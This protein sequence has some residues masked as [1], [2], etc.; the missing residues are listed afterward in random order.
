MTTLKD[1]PVGTIAANAATPNEMYPLLPGVNRVDVTYPS[2]T[3][4]TI[5]PKSTK[6]PNN[7]ANLGSV[8]VDGVA[9]SITGTY[10]FQVM[11]PGWLCFA[12]SGF[13]GANPIG[14]FITR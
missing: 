10:Q 4:A 11:G 12:V 5:T 3:S 8:F 2:G 9:V 13:S 7:T 14:V 6:D 1:R